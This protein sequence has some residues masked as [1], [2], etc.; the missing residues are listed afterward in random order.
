MAINAEQV[1][2]WIAELQVTASM[3]NN[4]ILRHI[5]NTLDEGVVTGR[6]YINEPNN[7]GKVN[8]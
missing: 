8:E 1:R 7:E 6:I 4:P 5:A 2:G 3:N